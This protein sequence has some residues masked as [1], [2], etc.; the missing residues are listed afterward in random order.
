MIGIYNAKG[1]YPPPKGNPDKSDVACEVFYEGGSSTGVEGIGGQQ[2]SSTFNSI[3]QANNPQVSFSNVETFSPEVKV[4]DWGQ[5]VHVEGAQPQQGHQG[6]VR[7]VVL[8]GQERDL[9][10]P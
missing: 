8:H 9:R 4:A 2:T 10:Q 1:K 3:T 7:R 5:V 6:A